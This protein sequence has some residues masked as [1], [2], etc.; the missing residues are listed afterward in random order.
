MD[1]I[2]ETEGL[3]RPN[4]EWLEHIQHPDTPNSHKMFT[5]QSYHYSFWQNAE[6]SIVLIDESGKFIDA[7]P[8]FLD[9]VGAT[10]A[11]LEG[12]SF[13]DLVD[14]RFFKRDSVNIRA[15]ID[16]K[17][18]SYINMTQLKHKKK[19]KNLIPVK[20]VATR[21]PATLN[22]P[23]RHIIIH[24]YSMPDS[25]I[26]PN[27][28]VLDMQPFEWKSLIMQPWFIKSTFFLVGLLSILIALSGHLTPIL[29][30]L[31]DKL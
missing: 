28:E 20:V 17:I 8:R 7:N 26:I 11:E 4:L 3:V 22:H 14:A 9:L 18:Y 27:K 16:S 23:F 24:L 12:K 19:Q 30:K 2:E 5:D 25:V 29:D 10:F 31:L 1:L 21:I 13:F 15:I 6:H